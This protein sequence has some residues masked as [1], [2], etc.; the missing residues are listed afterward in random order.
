MNTGTNQNPVIRFYYT[1]RLFSQVLRHFLSLFASR[2]LHVPHIH[3]PYDDPYINT[4]FASL[5][6]ISKIIDKT[7]TYE[8]VLE[9]QRSRAVQQWCDQTI[10]HYFK[11]QDLFSP[12]HLITMRSAY[13]FTKHTATFDPSK[14]NVAV[15]IRRGD[16]A[17]YPTESRYTPLSFFINTVAYIHSV[18]PQAK[19]HVYSDSP[20]DLGFEFIRYHI[21][22]DLLETI[23]DMICADILI[24]S[25]GSNMSFFAG[26]L[27]QGLVTFDW[28][29]L[30]E[31]F[32]AELNRYWSG[33]PNFLPLNTF[34]NRLNEMALKSAESCIL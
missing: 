33:H 28:A 11:I 20:V 31:P 5:F 12:A 19:I 18:L 13:I 16:I 9:M 8:E 6:D 26:L 27:S 24:M 25:V 17:R 15:H 21:L 1:D 30:E 22:E 2:I 7:S 23:H 14:I 32:N 3:Y 29:K 10:G 34:R 4:S